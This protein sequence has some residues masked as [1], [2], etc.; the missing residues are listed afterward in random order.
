MSE[1]SFGDKAVASLTN[2][3]ETTRNL[4]V[5]RADIGNYGRTFDNFYGNTSI[6]SQY[7]RDDYNSFKGN[8][9]TLSKDADI[10][11]ACMQVYDKVGIVK[12]IIDLYSDFTCKGIRLVHKNPKTQK[13]YREW[14]EFINGDG[15]SERFVNY[16]YRIA[17]VPVYTTYGTLPVKVQ[18]KWESTY[19]IKIEDSKVEKRRIPL[20]YNFI[21]PNT[22]EPILPELSMFTGKNL[23]AL[24]IGSIIQNAIKKAKGQYKNI[25]A[26][27]ILNLI[28]D[29]IKS[30]TTG[31]NLIPLSTD[32]LNVYFYKKDDWNTWAKPMIYSILDDI[33]SLEKMKLADISALEGVISNIRLWK[34]GVLTDNPQTCIIP[35]PA[36]LNKVREVLSMNTG[37]GSIDLVWGP[38]L[39][40]KESATQVHHFLGKE[41]YESVYHNI[42]QGL[43]FGIALSGDGK[44][45]SQVAMQT[46]T[47]RLEYGRSILCDFWNKEIKQVQKAMG[48]TSP[49]KVQ[50][51]R[52]TFGDETGMMKLFIELSDRGLITDDMVHE[53]FDF[54]PE[55]VKKKMITENKA[56]KG[57]RYPDKAGPYYKP[58]PEEELKK[59]IL[60]SG[61]VTPSEVGLELLEKKAGEVPLVDKT[62]E[63]D[64]KVA[65]VG[66]KNALNKGVKANP[67]KLNGRPKN[68][69]DTVNRKQR[70]AKADT[71][72]SRFLWANAAQKKISELITDVWVSE[73]CGKKDVRSLTTAEAEELEL[74]KFNILCNVNPYSSVD[75]D[76]ITNSFDILDNQ[77]RTDISTASK[78]LYMSFVKKNN[79]EP[80]L[81]EKRQIQASAYSLYFEEETTTGINT[82]EELN[83][84][85]LQIA[86]ET[87]NG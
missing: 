43:G 47:E 32:N 25:S 30:L 84:S 51:D 64:L 27:D 4:S 5:S 18:K 54:F 34:V 36:M 62:H 57:K 42:Y 61:G 79:R 78:A 49:A 39:D 59:I 3:Y 81:D 12:N 65:K 31:S 2:T 80:S 86:K 50:F 87:T 67:P 66:G 16:L 8:G 22:L 28:P 46:L 70:V 29:E 52:I 13:F 26:D 7:S 15:I 1:Q 63:Q 38:E 37:G 58:N 10:Q 82:E 56:R 45:N 20:R 71:F 41:K 76:T 24:K 6:K 85:T 23:Y 75:I 60:Q 44:G 55:I 17:N 40:F 74:V 72:V 35:S 33:Q 11:S 77:I 21:N 19:G 48:F 73:S 53:I 14:F 9:N 83:N 68:A 69:K